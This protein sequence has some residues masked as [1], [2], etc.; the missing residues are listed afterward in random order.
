MQCCCCCPASWACNAAA[1]LLLRS[2]GST[3]TTQIKNKAL[4]KIRPNTSQHVGFSRFS[5]SASKN[6]LR[7]SRARSV[8]LHC[9]CPRP[10]TASKEPRTPLSF[11]L[12]CSECSVK[13]GLKIS[14]LQAQLTFRFTAPVKC[15]RTRG[16]WAELRSG[17]VKLRQELN[18]AGSGWPDKAR[19][20]SAQACTNGGTE[21]RPW[22]GLWRAQRACSTSSQRASVVT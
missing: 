1:Q 3:R 10:T 5:G 12:G 9:S 19:L 6:M 15:E 4:D 18:S 13:E 7:M 2:L 11:S 17:L 20:E 21:I 16:F 8:W 14:G 22:R